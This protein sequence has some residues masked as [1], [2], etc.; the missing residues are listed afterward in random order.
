MTVAVRGSLRAVQFGA[1]NIG[2]GFIA[3]LFHESGLGVTFVD[4]V[5]PVVRAINATGA[6]T[7][8]IVGP[9]A[10]DVRIDGVDAIH[11]ADRDAVAE[12]VA[13]C[14]IAC[15]AV[16]AG[17]LRHIA[18]NLA[19]GLDLRY[20]RGG[21]P[22]NI[23]VCENLHDA[24]KVLRELVGA[25]LPD[26][27]REAC[28]SATGFVQ[29]VV[30]RMVPIQTPDPNDPLTVRVEAYKRL[31]VDASAAVGRLPEVC[32]VEP[33]ANFAAHESRK[34]FTHNCAHAALGYLGWL[35]GIEFGYEALDNAEVR[36]TLDGALGESGRAL[37]AR[38][39]FEAD[40]HK[41][42]VEDLLV[43]FANVALGDTCFR[44][45]R[46]P[47]RKLAPHDRLVGAARLCESCD[48]EPRNLARVVGAALKFNASDDPSA[49][50]L[51]RR[52]AE[53]GLEPTLKVV[54]GL[55]AGEPLAMTVK[56]E[57]AALGH[58]CT[59]SHRGGR[60]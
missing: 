1:G 32:G 20:R 13:G 30:S 59:E 6:Y 28:L 46:D 24:G 22:L 43:R 19:A 17:A 33:V 12:A 4:V 16:G 37:V 49:V 11:G 53:D 56:A 57:H 27:V 44:L 45:A 58:R 48:V 9:G 18:P 34:L 35:R 40:E 10:R 5:E 23:L 60:P 14:E 42:H 39:G 25:C 3:Q 29:A 26:D 55:E 21:P 8:R 51:Q 54:C 36:A 31:P 41:A 38:Y 15:T 2:R 7:I 50:E 47:L 52:I